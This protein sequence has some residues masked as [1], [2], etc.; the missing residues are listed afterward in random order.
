MSDV[1]NGPP[2]EAK[3]GPLALAELRAVLDRLEREDAAMLID[4][5]DRV[6]NT[7]A[8]Q[9]AQHM[10][11]VAA[12][13]TVTSKERHHLLGNHDVKLL[14][15]HDNQNILGQPTGH[16]LLQRGG[17][18]LLLWSPAPQF[19]RDGCIVGHDDIEWLRQALDQLEGPTVI[20]THVP[21]GGGSMR[22]NYYFEGDPVAGASYRDLSQLQELVL[23]A[24]HVKLAVAGHVHWNSVNIIDGVPFLTIQSLSELA[25]TAPRPAG[26]WARL[27]LEPDAARLE[28]HGLDQF[29]VRLPLRRD[30][31]HWL[32]RPGMPAWRASSPLSSPAQARGLILDLD[33]VVY[34]GEQLLPGAVEFVSTLHERG[35]RLVAVSNHSGASAAE[36]TNKLQRLGVPLQEAQ[37]MT[38]IDATVAYLHEHYPAKAPTLV[39][40]SPALQAAVAAAGFLPATRPALVIIGYQ[41]DRDVSELATA[42]TAVAAG[43]ALIGTN[44]DGWLPSADGT[45]RPESG[46]Y[47][48]MVAAMAGRQP[49]AVVGKPNHVIGHLALQRL[50]LPANEVMVVGDTLATDIGLAKS[51]G[52]TSAL[53]LTGNTNDS[54]LLVPRPDFVYRDLRELTAQ[55]VASGA[56][57]EDAVDDAVT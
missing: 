32:R 34:R 43:A 26:A 12:A 36:L 27:R 48:A 1:H 8:E 50:G 14:S 31:R 29:Q 16:R 46:P 2:F 4:L 6:N 35:T 38:S 10:A 45:R 24:D 22:G 56:A 13:F 23:A 7:S 3:A 25:T 30:G 39:V 42:A 49:A 52:A 37:V 54:D 19:R 20:F 5:G 18:T 40:G 57:P 15:P 17:W 21:L 11:E 51:I 33:G 53:V 9:D 28:V 41:N 47:L 55:L 44:S